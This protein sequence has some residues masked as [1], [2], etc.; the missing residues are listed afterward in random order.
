MKRSN[1]VIAPTFAKATPDKSAG[2][3]HLGFGG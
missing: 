2:K 1:S 3:L